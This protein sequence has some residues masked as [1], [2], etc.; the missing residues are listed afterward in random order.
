MQELARAGFRPDQLA[1]LERMDEY[2][3]YDVLAEL[4]YGM[5]PHTRLDRASSIEYKHADWLK[6][7]PENT[8]TAIRGLAAVFERNGTPGLESSEVFDMVPGGVRAL[9][10][11]AAKA[12]R[13][14]KERV[15]AP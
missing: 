15:F 8:A 4:G 6:Q 5:M 2:D 11:D 3:L 12:L 10:P 14:L 9:A 1:R 13:E 7:L